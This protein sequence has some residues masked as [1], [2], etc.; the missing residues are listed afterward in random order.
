MRLATSALSSKNAHLT[1]HVLLY[2]WHPEPVWESVLYSDLHECY[3]SVITASL[4]GGST[5]LHQVN[6]L[7]TDW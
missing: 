7:S 5:P 6:I 4:D 3:E 2:R 1:Q